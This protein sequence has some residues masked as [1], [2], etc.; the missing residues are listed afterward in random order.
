MSKPTA[1]HLR[2]LPSYKTVHDRHREHHGPGDARFAVRF[3]WEFRCV[4]KPT[5]STPYR[6][7]KSIPV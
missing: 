7:R 2:E 4:S 6:T 1:R 5:I 3:L